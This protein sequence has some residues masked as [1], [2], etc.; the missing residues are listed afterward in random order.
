VFAGVLA[1]GAALLV[2]RLPPGP[3]LVWRPIAVAVAVLVGLGCGLPSG[4]LTVADAIG[5]GGTAAVSALL[6]DRVLSRAHLP[7]AGVRRTAGFADLLVPMT[8]LVPL[9]LASP[10]AYLAGRVMVAGAG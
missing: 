1:S 6:T 7:A 9:A 4:G 10:I 5:V 3:D 8:V 2:V